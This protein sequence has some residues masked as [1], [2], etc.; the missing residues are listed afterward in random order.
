VIKDP[1]WTVLDPA[2]AKQDDSKGKSKDK[3]KDDESQQLPALA[4]GQD[5]DK[6]KAELKERK[7]SP[8]KPYDDAT[9]LAAMKNAGQEI[10]DEDL[11]SYM[12]QKGLGTPATRAAIIERLLQTGYIER[13][14][15]HLLPTEKGKALIEQVHADLRDVKLTASWEQQLADMQDGKL[16]L[17]KFEGDIA[18]FVS[19]LLPQVAE[20]SATTKLIPSEG[21]VGSCPKCEI[22]VVR[23]TPKGAGCIRWKDGCTFSIWREQYGKELKDAHIKELVENRRTKLIKGFKKKDGKDKYDACLV[24]NEE[25]KVRLDFGDGAKP[26]DTAFG[27]CPQ[28]K[29]GNVRPNSKGVGCSRWKEG[30]TFFIWREQAGVMIT[31]D[32][33]TQLI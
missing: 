24:L 2:P 19:T 6:R 16:V 23:F 3:D 12:K 30:C 21:D 1:G 31:D 4:K 26:V 15:K 11:A 5:V 20:A 13:N 18:S 28:C 32:H 8:P 17:D 27:A 33:I 10:D 22:G 14:K 9:L 7:T 29:E 25:C